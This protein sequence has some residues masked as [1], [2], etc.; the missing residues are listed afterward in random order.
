MSSND[1]GQ[2]DRVANEGRQRIPL[3]I[4]VGP[5][6]AGKSEV[7]L[8]LA[9]RLN[10]EIVSADS[11]LFYRGMDIGT[12]KPSI[13]DRQRIHHHLIDVANP[14]ET[15][16]LALFQ[17]EANRVI[18]A[19]ASRD[20]LPIMVGGT[21]QFVRSVSQGWILPKVEPNPRLRRVLEDWSNTISPQELHS[22]LASLDPAAASAIDYQNVRRTI[23]AL[24][25]IFTTGYR[26]SGQMGAGNKQFQTLMI[27]L[28]RSRADLYQRIDKRIDDMIAEGLIDE[29]HHLLDHGYSPELPT[30][31]AI[32]YGE[33]NLYIEGKHTLE[34]AVLLMKRRTRV[35]VRRQAN[36]FKA[37]DPEIHWYQVDDETVDQ[38]EKFIRGWLRI[39]QLKL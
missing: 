35:L 3:V 31:S 10:G 37:D 28:N 27:G 38:A 18:K 20:H 1:H 33:I 22:K 36:W 4:I 21:G 29:V 14:D 6:A 7:S 24:E 17:Q 16:S 11:R 23:R 39:E 12:A 26:F 13:V 8:Q 15:W 34:E 32:G 19:I 2:E 5:T 30:M 25:V 9:V